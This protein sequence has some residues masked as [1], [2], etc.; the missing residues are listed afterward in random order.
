MAFSPGGRYIVARRHRPKGGTIVTPLKC[1]KRHAE[2]GKCSSHHSARKGATAC[3]A[4]Q[5]SH[6]LRIIRPILTLLDD[7]FHVYSLLFK[8]CQ[9]LIPCVWLGVDAILVKW[10]DDAVKTPRPYTEHPNI[11]RH[12]H[13][14]FIVDALYGTEIRQSALRRD[15]RTCLYG[16][17]LGFCYCFSCFFYSREKTPSEHLS[18]L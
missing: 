13:R 5:L 7:D 3:R 12:R 11:E 8:L 10:P 14:Q 4:K 17:F 9:R 6:L 18:V 2:W 1:P 16:D 15:A